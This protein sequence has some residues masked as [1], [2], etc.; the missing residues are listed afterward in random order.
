MNIKKQPDTIPV[1]FLLFS[2]SEIQRCNQLIVE[3]EL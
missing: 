2:Y 1:A 3:E